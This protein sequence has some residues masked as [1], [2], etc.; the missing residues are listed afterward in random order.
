MWRG[1][2]G[3]YHR[4]MSWNVKGTFFFLLCAMRSG[5]CRW[6]GRATLDGGD[7][8]SHEAVPLA[9]GSTSSISLTRTASC[10][11][12]Q[13]H[14]NHRPSHHHIQSKPI[15][16]SR[17]PPDRRMSRPGQMARSSQS[18]EHETDPRKLAH[19]TNHRT[20]TSR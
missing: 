10:P 19:K 7:D 14:T 5:L 6:C 8:A 3:V 20:S 17:P 2:M 12:L 16:L 11:C 13:S 18:N 15:R 1:S 9:T 4:G